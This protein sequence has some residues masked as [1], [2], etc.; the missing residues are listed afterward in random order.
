M[1]GG[2][3]W[4]F[5]T[6]KNACAT[7]GPEEEGDEQGEPEDSQEVPVEGGHG[8]AAALAFDIA[9]LELA[10]CA[11]AQQKIAKCGDSAHQVNAV[12]GGDHVE[13]RAVRIFAEVESLV[14]QF[15]EREELRAEEG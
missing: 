11:G 9:E 15:A 4:G 5:N 1:G 6:G 12:R 10:A 3:G 7:S 8:S 2:C 13:Q 14:D